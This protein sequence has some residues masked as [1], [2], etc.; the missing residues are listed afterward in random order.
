MAK[1]QLSIAIVGGG[2]GGLS[3]ALHLLRAGFDVQVFEQTP[4]SSEVGAGLVISPNASKLLRRLGITAE[5]DKVAVRP[6]GTHQRRWQ[7]GRTLALTRLREETEK[8][9]G[10]PHWIFHR[11]DLLA[12]LAHAVPAERMHLDHRCLDFS[13][14]GDRVDLKFENGATFT[15]D[16]L[17]GADGI[18]SRIRHILLGPERPRFTGCIAYRGLVPAERI[19]HLNIE[20]TTNNWMGPGRHFVHY[21]V[22]AGR[23]FNFVGL[24]EQDTWI[25]ESWTEPGDVAD[26]AAAYAHFHPQVRGIIA[27]ATETFKWALL[28][29]DPLPRWSFNRVTLLGDACHPMLPFLGQ[30]GAQAIEDGA[31]LA[32]CLQRHGDDVPRA[33]ELYQTLRLPRSAHCQAISRG[34]MTRYHLP[35]GPEQEARDAELASGKAGWS[36]G[37]VAWLYDHDA[38]V[39]DASGDRVGAAL[40]R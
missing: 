7:D 35:D 30:G 18:H 29:R 13:D 32:A 40:T 31:T 15:A 12:V 26:L 9:F 25:K 8:R 4:V 20:N 36:A 22:S 1:K 23:L 5:L 33:L 28:D 27:A 14:H 3:A 21:Y 39:L 17:V 16:M 34:N 10:A 38:S 19:A 37:A 2:I 11:G 24:L 6:A